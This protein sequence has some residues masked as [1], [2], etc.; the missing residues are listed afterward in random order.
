M[1]DPW[2]THVKAAGDERLRIPAFRLLVTRGPDRGREVAAT[3]AELTIGTLE[4]ND[5]RLSDPTVSRNH[6]ALE[7]RPDGF[8]LRDLG[9]T[10]GT[11]VAGIR[12]LEAILQAGAEL[13]LGETRLRLS[14]KGDAFEV[15]LH[16]GDC[17]GPLI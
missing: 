3:H 10:N 14:A 15:P 1:S 5:L 17:F 12:V 6:C 2:T 11:Y 4:G 9:S 16:P 8:R 7:A 13:E